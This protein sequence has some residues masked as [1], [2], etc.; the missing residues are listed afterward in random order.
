MSLTQQETHRVDSIDGIRV[1]FD[2]Y[3]QPGREVVL[4]IAH[5]F[6]K[7]KETS[8]FRRMAQAFAQSQ[9]VICMDFRGH[10]ASSGL[11]TFSAKEDAE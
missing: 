2:H 1:S 3:Y 7:S 5:G 9:D 8:T 6:F 10:G 4:V 11:F